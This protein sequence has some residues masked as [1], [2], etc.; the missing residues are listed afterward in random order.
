ME[1][2]IREGLIVSNALEDLP[3]HGSAVDL[4]D[5][6]PRWLPRPEGIVDP[7]RLQWKPESTV[8]HSEAFVRWVNSFLY[9][10][11][12]AIGHY[13]P[14]EDYCQQAYLWL[15]EDVSVMGIRDADQR[16]A[17]MLSEFGRCDR[18][19]LYFANK[20]GYIKEGDDDSGRRRFSAFH[21]QAIV[22]FLLD[23]GYSFMLGKGRQVG[24]TSVIGLWAIKRIMFRVNYYIKFITE[25]DKTGKEIFEDKIKYPYTDLP[26]WMKFAVKSDAANR[27]WLSDKSEKGGEGF[28]NSRIEVVAP[29]TTAINGGSPQ[30]ALIDEAGNIGILGDMLNEARPT[31]YWINPVTGKFEMKRQV[32]FWSTGGKMTK[33]KGAYENE[34]YRFLSM[35]EEGKFQAGIVPLFFSWHVRLSEQDYLKEKAYYYGGNRSS[36][37]GIDLET[38]K[39]QFHQH[40]PT[41][42]RDM[43]RATSDT[44]VSQD[45]ISEGIDRVRNM[46]PEE[47]GVYGYFEPIFDIN[48]PADEHN[49]VP[50]RIIGARFIPCDDSNMDRTTV[51]MVHKPS[52]GWYHRYYQG[53]DPIAAETGTSNHA[54]TVLDD[55]FQEPACILN[56]RK[57]YDHKYVFLQCLLM[58]LYYDI[59]SPD[60][61]KKGI[62]ELVEANIGANYIDYKTSKGYGRSLVYNSQLPPRFRGGPQLV[63]VDNK[64][65]RALAIIDKMSETINSYHRKFKAEVIFTQLETFNRT[66]TATGKDVWGPKNKK[67]NRDDVL[68]STTYSYICK[69]AFPDRYP[70]EEER[71]VVGHKT[72]YELVRMPDG[73]LKRKAK[74]VPCYRRSRYTNTSSNDDSA[75]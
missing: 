13:K 69:E 41:T 53:T 48:T 64:G 17:V 22:L 32:V 7:D 39:T 70:Y 58:G 44:L 30:V 24:A 38:S 19:S 52:A 49:D 72:V 23:S 68:F 50:Y 37:L 51:F 5:G 11:F 15:K 27:L 66:T 54:S 56:F 16:R 34:W 1:N 43:F 2:L 40:Y 46:P 18:N 4:D 10:A 71:V 12:S 65:I 26:K 33:S 35:W 9:H 57:K 6:W 28:P 60:G 63:G 45:I 75:I 31:L 42:F 55:L 61:R 36:E 8:E 59:N 3:T 20:Y 21:H 73:T 29:S 47:R 67:I 25:D 14:F 62:P 74:R